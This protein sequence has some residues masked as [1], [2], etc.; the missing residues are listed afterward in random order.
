MSFKG[1]LKGA[2]FVE[3]TSHGPN[4]AFLIIGLLFAQLGRQIEW[5]AHHGLSK[6]V[7]GQHFS[8]SQVPDLD[9]LIFVHEDV[10][11]LDIAMQYFVLVDVLKAEAD[12]NKES[13][14]F[15]LLERSFIL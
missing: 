9:L 14:Y 5:R 1:M 13:P 8:H 3:Q 12:F 6:L 4:V 2:Q 7:T 10:E 11:G 15:V